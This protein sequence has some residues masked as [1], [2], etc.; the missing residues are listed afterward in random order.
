MDAHK[1]NLSAIKEGIK[2]GNYMVTGILETGELVIALIND[3]D[4]K[5][6]NDVLSSDKSSNEKLKLV[7]N[8]IEI[9]DRPAEELLQVYEQ[10]I[11][12]KKQICL[13]NGLK[14]R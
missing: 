3:S 9:K 6:L 2:R 8:L 14:L 5:Y 13:K 12:N 7:Q 4:K 1:M 11:C 10:N